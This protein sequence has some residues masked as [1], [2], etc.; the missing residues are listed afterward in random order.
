MESVAIVSGITIFFAVLLLMGGPELL[1]WQAD[2]NKDRH[3]LLLPALKAL[4]EELRSTA[5]R[6]RHYRPLQADV[7]RETYGATRGSME[8]AVAAFQA[9][10]KQRELLRLPA[11]GDEGL[12][13]RHFLE[14][15]QYLAAIPRDT[16]RLGR[17]QRLQT[18]ARRSLKAVN[19]GLNTLAQVPARLQERAES[20]S[21]RRLQQLAT[22]L[23]GE[24]SAGI[25]AL[26]RWQARQEELAEEAEALAQLLRREPNQPLSQLDALAQ[27]L[28]RVE[29]S[30]AALEEEVTALV[31]ERE[32]V[33]EQ[34]QRTQATYQRLAESEAPAVAP[35]LARSEGLLAGA[36]AA[37]EEAD[38]AG[39]G[40]R[41]GQARALLTL[42][43]DLAQVAE[44]VAA[45]EAVADVSLEATAIAELSQA[46]S[47]AQQMVEGRLDGGEGKGMQQP[48][49]AGTMRVVDRLQRQAR[50][51]D[52]RAGRLQALHEGHVRELEEEAGREAQ[53]LA[54]AWQR[55]GQL[56]PPAGGDP[57][58]NRYELLQR[59]RTEAAGKPALLRAYVGAARGLATRVADTAR[60]LEQ[61]LEWATGL[62]QEISDLLSAAETEAGGW[63]ALQPHVDQI[64]ES[65]AAIWQLDPAA[66]GTLEEAYDTLDELQ[67]RQEQGLDAWEALQAGRQRLLAVEQRIERAEAALEGAEVAP[68]EWQRVEQLAQGYYADARQAETIDEALLA[69]Q[70]VHE[71]LRSVTTRT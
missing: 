56:V 65:A 29:E 25:A 31:S 19:E 66:A 36:N 23:S 52:A 3:E 8:E 61:N 54:Q 6:L 22:T 17:L 21:S 62:R 49:P 71:V 59:Q 35:L 69:L 68:E 43:N 53:A 51:M 10:Q 18:Q 42:A 1:R 41:A 13:I 32:T 28:T 38:F 64:K 40:E 11:V 30:T 24:K 47:R 2:R 12:A 15:P 39:A 34:L 14:R 20:L 48:L 5:A 16:L 7:Y 37:R 33:D 9:A 60:Y 44:K 46:H 67:A 45:L 50:E 55:L 26:D 57:L 70:E 27:A 4:A 58:T 63:R